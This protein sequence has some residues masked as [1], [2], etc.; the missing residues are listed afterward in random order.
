MKGYWIAGEREVDIIGNNS[1]QAILLV[2]QLVENWPGQVFNRE[3]YLKAGTV[4]LPLPGYRLALY[5]L[6]DRVLDIVESFSN[7]DPDV[8][9]KLISGKTVSASTFPIVPIRFFNA[10][11]ETLGWLPSRKSLLIIG[12]EEKLGLIE[13]AG[14]K[15]L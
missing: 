8:S 4:I 12:Q 3:S 9:A 2:A 15:I 14:G 6:P 7:T 1:R 13:K 10:D 11:F 5:P